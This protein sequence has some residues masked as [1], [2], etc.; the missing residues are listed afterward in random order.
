MIFKDYSCLKSEVID[1][2]HPTFSVCGISALVLGFTLTNQFTTE[3]MA[4]L[5]T[6]KGFL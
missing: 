1:F 6:R 3:N 5:F 4:H 2:N